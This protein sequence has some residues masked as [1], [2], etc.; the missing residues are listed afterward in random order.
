[1][2]EAAL[3]KSIA[4]SDKTHSTNVVMKLGAQC[5]AHK[6]GGMGPCKL[7]LGRRRRRRRRRRRNPSFVAESKWRPLTS[8]DK[9]KPH[10]PSP[11]PHTHTHSLTHLRKKVEKDRKK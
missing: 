9:D 8:K 11:P 7:V 10:P 5:I 2:R 4:R 3:K 1:M 6:G